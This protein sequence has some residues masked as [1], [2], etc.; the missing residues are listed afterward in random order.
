MRTPPLLAAVLLL[1]A[2]VWLAPAL[3]VAQALQRAVFVS[4]LDRDGAPV[5]NL[6]P[7][8]VVVRE[9]NVA[10]EVLRVVP[11]DEP[12][13]MA[14]LVDDSQYAEQYIRDYRVA[15]T[16]FITTMT[17]PLDSGARNEIALVALAD[18][19]TILSD[20]TFDREQLLRGVNR[21][22]ASTGSGT[23]L[24]DAIIDVSRGVMRRGSRRPVIVALTSEGLEL[25]N[26]HY[27]QVLEPLRLSGAALHVVILGRRVNNAYDRSMVL[28]EGPRSTG[29][30]LDTLL[31]GTALTNYLKGLANELL[32]QYRITYARPQT[33]IPPEQV[34]VS[35]AR[36]GLTVR[37][38]AVIEQSQ[39]SIP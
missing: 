33:L 32:H 39:R 2:G 10:R 8:D 6:G 31:T 36:P 9:D 7:S 1:A 19:P 35:A 23:Y 12:I 14:I 20:Y 29:G 3:L 38:T 30:R 25:S 5:P 28:D 21:I 22:F 34:T 15:L 17:E 16:D 37:G 18:R 11:A 27:N 26:R 4:A 24:L 13:Q